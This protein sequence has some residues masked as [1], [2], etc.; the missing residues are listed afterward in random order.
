[1]RD[2]KVFEMADFV[3]YYIEN[4]GYGTS[5][6][7]YKSDISF[8]EKIHAPIFFF[9]PLERIKKELEDFENLIK[10]AEAEY[11]LRNGI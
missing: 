10:K 8:P 3:K 7:R 6:E 11:R 4:A 5:W 9:S 2:R 1:M